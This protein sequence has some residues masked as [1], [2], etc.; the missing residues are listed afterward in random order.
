MSFAGFVFDMIRR[1]K[2]NRDLRNLRRERLGNRLDK[3]HGGHSMPQNTTVEDMEEIA[4]QTTKKEQSELNYSV[5]MTLLVLAV[6]IV[7]A[8]ILVIL[9]IK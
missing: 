7:I 9:F 2:E 3:M 8:S 5:K 1:D 4:K 6:C